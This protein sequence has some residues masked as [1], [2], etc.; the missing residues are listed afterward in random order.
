MLST[1]SLRPDSVTGTFAP[2][3]QRPS[4]PASRGIL[5]PR[6]MRSKFHF[7]ICSSHYSS[8][9]APWCILFL[10]ISTRRHREHGV[11]TEKCDY[12]DRLLVILFDFAA[13]YP[14]FVDLLC[15]R[16][17]WAV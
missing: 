11:Y 13:G 10:G 17:A 9:E 8:R 15:S 3:T 12:S 14:N 4:R 7:V 5:T 2:V 1:P 16:Q 6:R